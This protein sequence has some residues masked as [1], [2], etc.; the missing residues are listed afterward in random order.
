VPA[1]A[2]PLP[3]AAPAEPAA[4][5]LPADEP[6][7]ELPPVP[8]VPLSLLLPHAASEEATKK[9]PRTEDGSRS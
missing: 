6:P 7:A 2:P 4:P 9:T 8:D 5:P 3:A 1:A